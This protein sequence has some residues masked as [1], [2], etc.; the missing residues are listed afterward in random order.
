MAD[1]QIK[2][3]ADW[4]LHRWGRYIQRGNSVRELGYP[5]CSAEQKTPGGS[6]GNVT[7]E[8]IEEDEVAEL[9]N[10]KIKALPDN[11]QVVTRLYYVSGLSV[12]QICATVGCSYAVLMSMMTLVRGVAFAAMV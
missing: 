11:Y 2:Q 7:Q 5:K 8:V 1:D 9:V 6:V 12:R 10:S 3:Q 4:V